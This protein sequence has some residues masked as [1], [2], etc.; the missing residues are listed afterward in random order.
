[1]TIKKIHK[2]PI[3]SHIHPDTL[4]QLEEIAE[5]RQSTLSQVIRSSIAFYLKHKPKENNEY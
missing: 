2:V 3:H 4:K 5:E 1:M